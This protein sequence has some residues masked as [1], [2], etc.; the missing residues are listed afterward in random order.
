MKKPLNYNMINREFI[1]LSID[2]NEVLRYLGYDDK[3]VD[4]I[5]DKIIDKCFEEILKIARTNFVY[6]IFE[7]N[8]DDKNVFLNNSRIK[9]EGKDIYKHLEKSK[10]CAIMAVTLGSEVDKRIK[11][12]SKMD[13]TKSIILDACSTAA[14]E[15]LCDRVEALIKRISINNGFYTTKRYSPGYG[16]FPIEI[17]PR[18]LNLLDAQKHIGLTVTGSYILIPRKSVTAL[19]GIGEE[20]Q[21]K[22]VG[23]KDCNLYNNCLFVKKG[24]SCGN[25]KTIEK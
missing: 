19:I 1:D 17:Q 22:K 2:K 7:I 11:Y 18:I 25:S 16:D 10:K 24:D 23:C 13:L 14:I 3:R 15:A 5:T 20:F 21:S 4:D 6:N 9:L 12:Y 8:R